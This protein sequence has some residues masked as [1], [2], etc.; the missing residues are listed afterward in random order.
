MDLADVTV[1]VAT[2]QA[3][4]AATQ[5]NFEDL[6]N[7]FAPAVR[8]I[9]RWWMGNGPDAEDVVQQVFLNAMRV[10]FGFNEPEQWLLDETRKVAHYAATRRSQQRRRS[11]T[12]NPE[13]LR[14]IHAPDPSKLGSGES[15]GLKAE[16]N[17]VLQGSS[18]R[19]REILRLHY[20]EN[21]TCPQIAQLLRIS[22]DAVAKRLADARRRF[23]ARAK[24]LDLESLLLSRRRA[25]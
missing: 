13:W 4:Q 25:S 15:S 11:S 5:V 10:H 17:E 19:D 18:D 6:W 2:S 12:V 8:D 7:R 24:S 9:A 14:D 16:V 23:R 1:A 3:A 21:L 22:R 20:W